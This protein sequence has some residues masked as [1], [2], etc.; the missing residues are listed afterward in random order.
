MGAGDTHQTLHGTETSKSLRAK[1]ICV[2]Q[3]KCDTE[4]YMRKLDRVT[5]TETMVSI[6]GHVLQKEGLSLC[7]TSSNQAFI[8]NCVVSGLSFFIC[9]MEI[10]ISITCLIGS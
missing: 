7:E 1:S 2:G 4:H 5:E 6:A 8:I 3:G 9:R 10:M